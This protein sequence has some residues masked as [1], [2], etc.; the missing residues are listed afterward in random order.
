MKTKTNKNI[1]T[2]LLLILIVYI[3]FYFIE[4]NKTLPSYNLLNDGVCILY[5]P[6]YCLSNKILNE[7]FKDD[8][9]KK[10]PKDYEFIDYSY[11]IKNTSLSYFHRDVTSSQIIYKTTHPV[12]TAIIYKNDGELL[13]VCPGSHSTY[14]FVNSHIV[15]IHGEAGTAILFNCELLHA[16]CKNLCKKREITQYKIC[17]KND[18]HLLKHLMNKHIEKEDTCKLS[19]YDDIKRKMTYY[20]QLPIN[21]IFAPLMIER[22]NENT[23]IGKIQQIIPLTFY[24]NT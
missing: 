24:N 3:I 19:I 10:L 5:D 14:P 18:L 23:M 7:R 8:I 21:T 16:G 2:I 9:L 13:S 1:S 20:F 15:N 6:I 4:Y 17:H 12:Y 11:T 22:K